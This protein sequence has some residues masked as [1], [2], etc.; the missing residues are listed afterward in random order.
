MKKVR[1]NATLRHKLENYVRG[2]INE[3]I[4]QTPLTEARRRLEAEALRL[5]QAA[6]PPEDMAI[7]ARY[8][9]SS[10]YSRLRFATPDGRAE[11]VEFSQAL[12][13]DLPDGGGYCFDPCIEAD[14]AFAAAALDA[15]SVDAALRAEAKR[16]WQ[17]AAVLV[18]CALYFEDV[19][20]YLGMPDSERVSL[21]NRWNLPMQH[22]QPT[23]DAD[24]EANPMD[25]AGGDDADEAAP[26]MGDPALLEVC[27]W[28]K[29]ELCE[30]WDEPE[31]TAIPEPYRHAIAAACAA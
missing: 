17:Q 22:S 14:A 8:G 13:H 25:E 27:L 31:E 4:D 20:D 3:G 19:L 24:E 29:Q 18:N 9:K 2:Q 16:Q 1:I 26:S 30:A 23:P 28:L 10:R 6:Y 12:P 7:L 15:A 5:V 21:A 11:T